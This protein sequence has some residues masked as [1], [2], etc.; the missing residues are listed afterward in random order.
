MSERKAINKYYPPD[1]DPSAVQKVKKKRNGALGAAGLLTVRLMTPFSMKCL[2]C[3]EYISKSRKFNAKKENTNMTYLGLKVVRFHI[4]CTRCSHEIVFRTDPKSA[5]YVIE[6]GAQRNYDSG[7][8]K[9]NLKEETIDETLERL[10]KEDE[11]DKL[12]K[13]EKE[14]KQTSLEELEAKLQVIRDQQEANEQLNDLIERNVEMNKDSTRNEAI[15]KL[16]RRQ[17][18]EKILQD[19]EDEKLANEIFANSKKL[20]GSIESIEG[21]KKVTQEIKKELIKPKIKRKVNKL[22]ISIKKIKK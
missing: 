17:I 6:S 1:F 3:N 22:G 21:D 11:L 5:D 10:E 7:K 13:I 8:N 14:K 12:S 2:N 19:E 16:E 4:K 15:K 18:I 9:V 20:V